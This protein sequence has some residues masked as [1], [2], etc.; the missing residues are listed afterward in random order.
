MS[1]ANEDNSLIISDRDREERE[2]RE[3]E[4]KESEDGDETDFFAMDDA[5]PFQVEGEGESSLYSNG[6]IIM[7]SVLI[8]RLTPYVIH[9]VPQIFR[10][11]L[12]G[13]SDSSSPLPPPDEPAP[14][15]N[16]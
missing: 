13:W 11:L 1:S 12:G 15:D 6:L 4:I 2:R 7:W 3:R 14:N 10:F 9:Y 5:K 8:M 16:L